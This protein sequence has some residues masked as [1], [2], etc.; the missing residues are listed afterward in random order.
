M[1]IA[2]TLK[3]WLTKHKVKYTSQKHKTAYT[4]QEIA[5]SQHVP[6]Q[7]LA[8]CVLV[9]TETS[10]CLA[11]LPA[12]HLVDFAKLKKLLKVKKVR[13]ASEA[14][15]KQAFPDI[16]VGAMSVFGNLYN[17]PTV[18]DKGLAASKDIVCNAGSHTDTITIRYEDFIKVA[19]PKVGAF[20]LHIA[21]AKKAKKRLHPAP[22]PKTT[23]PHTKKS[24]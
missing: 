15:I 2:A 19:K 5:A 16:D 1:A 9:K 23:R 17:I 22:L 20:G 18:V 4:A 11:V 21:D 14:D 10:P 6:G 12:I 3:T 13:L 24:P 8:K 7:Q